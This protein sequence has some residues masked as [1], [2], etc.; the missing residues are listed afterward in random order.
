MNA[1]GEGR[2]ALADWLDE[3]PTNFFEHDVRFA[4]TLERLTDAAWMDRM[5]PRLQKLGAEVNLGNIAT[6]EVIALETLRL[7]LRGDTMAD[8]HDVKM[9]NK[10][11]NAELEAEMPRPERRAR[12]SKMVPKARL[13]RVQ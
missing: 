8:F 1:T 5:R 2:N 11:R 3:Q 6:S 10:R 7:G 4:R 12:K 9:W 13:K